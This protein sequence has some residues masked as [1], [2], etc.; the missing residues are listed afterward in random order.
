MAPETTEYRPKK[1]RHAFALLTTLPLAALGLW[2]AIEP[3]FSTA[4]RLNG[5]LSILFF[6]SGFAFSL[7]VTLSRKAVLR[8]GPERVEAVN[9]FG[10]TILSFPYEELAELRIK[11]RGLTTFLVLV[12][13]DPKYGLADLTPALLRARKVN[14]A[15]FGSNSIITPSMYSVKPKPLAAEIER[16]HAAATAKDVAYPRPSSLLR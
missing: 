2:M 3:T 10:Y 9:P 8:L 7:A 11:R 1:S 14:L 4:Q 13:R 16:Y 6:G 15:A 5:L 12:P